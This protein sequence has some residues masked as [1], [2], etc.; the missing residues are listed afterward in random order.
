MGVG[1]WGVE[2]E[3]DEEGGDDSAG[4]DEDGFCD[5]FGGG[6]PQFFADRSVSARVGHE[7]EAARPT[8]A[9]IPALVETMPE[10]TPC[11]R[12]ATP[13]AAAMNMA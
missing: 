2:V 3:R 12:S 1:R 5:A 10:A 7:D 11:S 8:V 13:V 4:D 6:D 9:P